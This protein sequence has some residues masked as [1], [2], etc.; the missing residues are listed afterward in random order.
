MSTTLLHRAGS[1]ALLTDM[2]QLTMAY[3]Y[4]KAGLA[5]REAVFHLFFRENPFHGGFTLACGLGDCVKYMLG[6]RFGDNDIAYLAELRGGDDKALFDGAF[7]E[8]LRELRPRFDVEA[9]P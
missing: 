5:E 9:I 3:A 6:F 1:R 4:W 7:L 2:Y 8:Y